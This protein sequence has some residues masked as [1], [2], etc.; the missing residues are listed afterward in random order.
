MDRWGLVIAVYGTSRD[1]ACERYVDPMVR[2]LTYAFAVEAGDDAPCVVAYTSVKARERLE[3][4][5]EHVPDVAE[6]L[7]RLWRQ[8]VRRVVVADAHLVSGRAYRQVQAAVEAKAP[9]FDEVRL[10]GPL[11]ADARDVAAMAD[12]VC[13][14]LPRR[15]CETYVLVGHGADGAGQLAYLAL[16]YALRARGRSDVSI[17]LLRG[18]PSLGEVVAQLGKEAVSGDTVRLVPVMVAAAGHVERD[19]AGVWAPRLEAVGYAVSVSREGIGA[20]S[21]LCERAVKH[22]R[23]APAVAVSVG[24]AA[25]GAVSAAQSPAASSPCGHFPLFV[26]LAGADC[27]VVGAGAVGTR[28]AEALARF[29]ARVTVIDPR[30]AVRED[31]CVQMLRRPYETGDEEGRE[32]VVAAT[33]DRAV[34]RAIGERCR[35][36]GIPVSVADAAD[37]CTFFFPALCETDELVAG[38]ASRSAVPASHALVA[39]AAARIR[40]VLGEA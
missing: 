39:R 5:G 25:R 29:G 23:E 38:V 12:A 32:L 26:S 20:W 30:A 33:D 28:R 40:A 31:A 27:L 10:A 35:R 6:V 17:G 34:N 22:M 8:G 36:R 18:T 13:R 21:E 37:E 16:G 4:R 24:P 15:A 9:L 3:G 11:M 2:A 19:I 1:E 14:R 7:E